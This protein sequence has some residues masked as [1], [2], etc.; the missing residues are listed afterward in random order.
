MYDRPN[1][2]LDF[3]LNQKKLT[4]CLFLITGFL[5]APM[6]SRAG[7]TWYSELSD[8]IRTTIRLRA[9]ALI[10]PGEF[11]AKELDSLAGQNIPLAFFEEDIRDQGKTRWFQKLVVRQHHIPIVAQSVHA[12]SFPQAGEPV[13]IRMNE[14]DRVKLF[15]VPR[16]SYFS[17]SLFTFRELLYTDPGTREDPDSSLFFKLWSQSGK[18]PNLIAATT[19]NLKAI[20]QIVTRLNTTL[21][22]FGVV[23]SDGELVGGVSWKGSFTSTTSGYFCFPLI[24]EKGGAFVPYKPGYRFSPDIIYDS[25]ANRGFIKEFKALELK[26]D[27]ELTDHFV[28]RNR[29]MNL[30]RKNDQEIICNGVKLF[31]DKKRGDCAW[32]PGRAYIDAGTQSIA[33]LKPNFTVTAWINPTQLNDN[34]SIL[35]KGTN[36]VLKLHNGMLTYTMQGVRDYYSVRSRVPVNRW[37]F[38][39]LV[40]SAYEK[41]IRYYMNGRLTDQID[42]ISPYTESDHT[43]LIGSNLWE[44]FFIGA[45][46]EIKIWQRELNEEEIHQQYLDSL[47]GNRKSL[48]SKTIRIM[49]AVCLLTG[50]FLLWKNRR[51]FKRKKAG[52]LPVSGNERIQAAACEKILCFGGLRLINQDGA[53]ISRKFSPKIKQLFVLVFL[54]SVSGQKGITTK[55]LSGILWPGMSS[56]H[57]KNTRGTSIQNLKS[58]LASCSGVK[59]I[60]RDK[61][62]TID[63]DQSCYCDYTDVLSRMDRLEKLPED[64]PVPVNELK[65][66]FRIL[67]AG[68]LFPNMSESWLDPYI[69]KMSDRIIELGLSFLDR[70]DEIKHAALVYEMADVISLH[71]PLNEPALNKKLGML[72][73]Q[74]K[75][76]LAHTVYD[77]FT[78]LYQELYQESYPVDFKSITSGSE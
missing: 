76:S 28:F 38:I 15:P 68:T 54:H 20:T 22:I 35:G 26:S 12:A 78:K 27:F 16:D 72:T 9:H 17:D 34:N 77:H 36:F 23:R 60:F 5:L 21:R 19:S 11:T 44:E 3:P 67:N 65:A 1:N 10:H 7:V 50:M 74:G 41:R 14:F 51:I 24:P 53:D 33:T 71:D 58:I 47:D 13:F 69:S 4:Y 43:L 55:K 39:S 59:L 75:L 29:I 49:I 45:I 46:G 18:V 64:A 62:W 52:R 32:F 73:R 63:L 42:L 31:R 57:S 30:Q 2:D 70:T 66:L 48:L 61:L 56:Q 8:S 40:H 37:T 6:L 25:P